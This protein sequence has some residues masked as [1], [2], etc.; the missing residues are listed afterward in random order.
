MAFTQ[1]Q[2][3]HNFETTGGFLI[4]V[5]SEPMTNGPTTIPNAPE[6][7]PLTGDGGLVAVINATDDVGTTTVSG[8]P[9]TYT[10]Y[11]QLPGAPQQV[12]IT[13]ITSGAPEGVIDWDELPLTNGSIPPAAPQVIMSLNG[14]IVTG[15][16]TAAGNVLYSTSTT[17]ATWGTL[18]EAGIQAALSE[19]SPLAKTL[20]GTGNTIGSPS[21]PAG[22]DLTGTYPDPEVAGTHLALPLP[23]T[24]GGTDNA[25]GILAMEMGGDLEGF[26]PDP[27]VRA[28]TGPGV[29]FPSSVPTSG[30]G[31]DGNW[32]FYLGHIY[33]KTLGSWSEV[34]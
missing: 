23:L 22:G 16:P 29:L 24:Q 13:A 9:P 21:G 4:A 34:V 3:V 17:G 25:E 31:V 10:F 7:F 32:A 30:L 20:G 11:L 12:V 18:A 27:A 1:I 8:T 28:L 14:V 15:S 33:Y 5:L 26:L 19:G 6:S 2:L